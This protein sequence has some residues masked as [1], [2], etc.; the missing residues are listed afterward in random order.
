MGGD[1]DNDNDNDDDN[2]GDSLA[3]LPLPLR[4]LLL[5]PRG[6][7]GGRTEISRRTT[8]SPSRAD[9]AFADVVVE[10]PVVGRTVVGTTALSLTLTLRL[11]RTTSPHRCS[12]LIVITL[13]T[14]ASDGRLAP[15]APERNGRVR[16]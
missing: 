12:G 5:L 6:G 3:L 1:N 4:L 10:A 11:R 15:A 9:D 2:A 8:G 16:V 7:G 13:G 14:S